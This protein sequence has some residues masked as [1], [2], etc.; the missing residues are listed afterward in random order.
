MLENF[1]DKEAA[2]GSSDET[3]II[4]ENRTKCQRYC[5]SRK[6]FFVLS[7]PE[8]EEPILMTD[9]KKGCG[10]C[11]GKTHYMMRDGKNN[12]VAAH[13]FK[14]ACTCSIKGCMAGCCRCVTCGLCGGKGGCA[15][16]ELQFKIQTPTEPTDGIPKWK[17]RFDIEPQSDE[18]RIMGPTCFSTCC[19]KK[20]AKVE[21]VTYYPA[22]SNPDANVAE[23][24][25]NDGNKITPSAKG[26][27]NRML[28]KQ[29]H[30]CAKSGQMMCPVFPD[31]GG[32]PG[33]EA[34]ETLAEASQ[35]AADAQADGLF[36]NVGEKAVK[37]AAVAGGAAAVTWKKSKYDVTCMEFPNYFNAGQRAG[38][39][40]MA[41]ENSLDFK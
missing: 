5:G 12:I 24:T 18:L 2:K 26:Q 14:D 25:D 29:P 17:N 34:L 32:I 19:G 10:G 8:S 27:D 21:H 33:L 13:R 30:C 3:F 22:S 15:L 20:H 28:I 36:D 35:M 40:M 16:Y 37:T 31:G 7:K 38:L 9:Y 23:E 39:L 1:T 41:L 6:G 4:R 11:G